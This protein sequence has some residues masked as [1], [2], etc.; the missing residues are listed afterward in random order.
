MPVVRSSS[1]ANGLSAYPVLKLVTFLTDYITTTTMPKF[2]KRRVFQ[3]VSKF[4]VHFYALV[5]MKVA[6]AAAA[7]GS[8]NLGIFL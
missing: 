5:A 4:N 3:L 6:A 8:R 7:R 2:V 1:A